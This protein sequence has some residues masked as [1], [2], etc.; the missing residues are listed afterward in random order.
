MYENPFP[1]P[2]QKKKKKSLFFPTKADLILVQIHLSET[3]YTLLYF[4]KG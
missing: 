2:L 3:E 1:N 4:S